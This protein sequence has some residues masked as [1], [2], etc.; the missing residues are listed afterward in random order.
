MKYLLAAAIVAVGLSGVGAG[1]AM[2][3][4]TTSSDPVPKTTTRS[5]D[6]RVVHCNRA[7]TKCFRA[8]GYRAS[9]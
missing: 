3:D 2:A 6:A 4:K 9:R 5:S 7:G 8:H 1:R